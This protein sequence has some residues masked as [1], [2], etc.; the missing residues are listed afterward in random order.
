MIYPSTAMTK[1]FLASLQW[2]IV[3]IGADTG[4]KNSIAQPHSRLVRKALIKYMIVPV[5]ESMPPNDRRIK[6]RP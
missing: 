4:P 3:K 2:I 5:S 1:L 6:S